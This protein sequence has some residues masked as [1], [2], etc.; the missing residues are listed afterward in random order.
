MNIRNKKAFTLLELLMVVIIIG[1]LATIAMPQ[2]EKFKEKAI[3]ARA[4]NLL[5]QVVRAKT[6]L[7]SPTGLG[8]GETLDMKYWNGLIVVTGSVPENYYNWYGQVIRKDGPYESHTIEFFYE[9]GDLSK[10]TWTGNHPDT[11]GGPTSPGH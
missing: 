4:V 2:Y 9:D 11:P 10:P 8:E 3:A 5:S 7:G 6:M 1:I